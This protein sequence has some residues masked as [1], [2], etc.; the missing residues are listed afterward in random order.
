M[1][2]HATLDEA[3]GIARRLTED[4][5]RRLAEYV[6]GL[7]E[8]LACG[9]QFRD[10]LRW[11]PQRVGHCPFLSEASTCGIYAQR[12][13]SCRALLSTRPAAW[14]ATD[15]AAL[16]DWDRELYRQSLDPEFVAWPSHFIAATQTYARDLEAHLLARQK[17]RYGWSLSG[18]FPLLVWLE[19]EHQVSHRPLDVCFR[20]LTGLNA[21]SLFVLD[22]DPSKTSTTN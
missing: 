12:P 10:Y 5:S 6:D 11:H 2:V 3:V 22:L 18:N 16:D 9:V 20:R 17:S 19:R 15:L 1:A 7:K 21:E 13:L 4:Q 8:V 14:C